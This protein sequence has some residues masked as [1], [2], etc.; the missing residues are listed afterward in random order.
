MKTITINNRSIDTFF[1]FLSHLDINSKRRLI[2]KLTE[3]I[4]EPDN[5]KKNLKTLF[6]S[7]IDN[8]DSDSIIKDI[9]DSRVNKQNI[10]DF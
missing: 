6:G 2:M 5:K 10:I 9:L 3:S 7:W 1:G 8:R 4:D